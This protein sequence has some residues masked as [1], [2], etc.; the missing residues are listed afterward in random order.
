[1]GFAESRSDWLSALS[2]CLRAGGRLSVSP[3]LRLSVC[4]AARL[5]VYT[6]ACMSTCLSLSR[7]TISTR[8]FLNSKRGS[9]HALCA[10]LFSPCPALSPTLHRPPHACLCVCIYQLVGSG[11]AGRPAVSPPV[12]DS[13]LCLC[14]YLRPLTLS[15]FTHASLST[16][17]VDLSLSRLSVFRSTISARCF[18]N[19]KRRFLSLPGSVFLAPASSRLSRDVRLSLSVCLPA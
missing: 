3:S 2:F 10:P 18:L 17:P 4:L 8:C 16:C 12:C 14:V 19:P 1:M 13:T 7:S 15:R 6:S 5:P 11:L 9:L